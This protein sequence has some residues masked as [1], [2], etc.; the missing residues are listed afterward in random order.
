M[1]QKKFNFIIIFILD[2]YIFL[3]WQLVEKVTSSH[4]FLLKHSQ[5]FPK[6]I[7]NLPAST[8]SGLNTLATNSLLV[9]EY[10]TNSNKM[11]LKNAKVIIPPSRI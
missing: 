2:F 5:A 4:F 9:I 3:R 8:K 7:K 10:Y 6:I 1:I 11:V